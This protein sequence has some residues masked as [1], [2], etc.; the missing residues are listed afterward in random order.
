MARE[1][2][3]HFIKANVSSSSLAKT[4]EESRTLRRKLGSLGWSIAII[5]TTK[6][7]FSTRVPSQLK[8]QPNKKDWQIQTEH[9]KLHIKNNLFRIENDIIVQ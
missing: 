1:V 5:V 8:P 9:Y 7:V 4:R 6:L 2:L 3:V